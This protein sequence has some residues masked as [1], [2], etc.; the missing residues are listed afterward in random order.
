MLPKN[1]SRLDENRLSIKGKIPATIFANEHV[2][3]EDAAVTELNELLELQDTVDNFYKLEPSWF[4]ERPVIERVSLSPDFHKGAGIPIGTTMKTRGFCVPQA[5]GNDINCGVRVHTTSFSK[6]TIVHNLDKLEPKLRH[7]F[8][9]GGRDISFTQEQRKILLTNG[10]LGLINL[11]R[12]TDKS[13]GIWKYVDWLQ[14]AEDGFRIHGLGEFDTDG[15]IWGLDDYVNREGISRDSQIGSIGG[16]NHFLELQYV[17]KILSGNAA[18]QFGLKKNDVVLMVHSG[19]V[20]IGHLCGEAYK[21]L[22]KSIYPSKL[23]YPK[24]GIFPLPDRHPACKRF[25]TALHNAANFA[26]CN[27]TFLALMVRQA[28]CEVIGDHAFK[29]VYDS[30]H[31][32]VWKNGGFLHRKGACPAG[33]IGQGADDYF[34]EVVMIPGSMGSASFI[35]EGLGNPESLGTASHGAGRQLSRGDALH[36]SEADFDQFLRDY[37]VLTPVDPNRQDIKNRP[38]IVQ[39]WRESLKKEAP[40]AYK[41]IYPIIDTL[42]DAKIAKPVA[43]L[44][45]LLTLKG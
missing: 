22:V 45:P 40:F 1:C 36:H 7:I 19:S 18:F 16:G 15:E 20:S 5:V 29:L 23:A 32:L 21:D 38:E 4:S 10:I 43:E 14:L 25:F 41:S 28:L 44:R 8:F 35:M 31:N 9:E 11:H 33:G 3:V 24:N 39:K 30:P 34:G 27:R 17:Y 26:F 12:D 37:R 6:D 13:D 2:V 42:T